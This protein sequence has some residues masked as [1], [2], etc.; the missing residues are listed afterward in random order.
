MYDCELDSIDSG[1]C[2]HGNGL[3]RSTKGGEF[4]DR[5]RDYQLLNRDSAPGDPAPKNRTWIRMM[6]TGVKLLSPSRHQHVG[7]N[8]SPSILL[9]MRSL[10]ATT[11]K[12]YCTW[13]RSE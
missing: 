4:V 5:L 2:E 6:D 1:S 9:L 7:E 13:N 8:C 11:E 10:V 12:S 3:P